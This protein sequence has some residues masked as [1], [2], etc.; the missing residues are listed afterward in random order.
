MVSVCSHGCIVGR[1]RKFRVHFVGIYFSVFRLCRAVYDG[2]F[3]FTP[4]PLNA[5]L[6]CCVLIVITLN[7]QHCGTCASDLPCTIHA[8]ARHAVLPPNLRFKFVSLTQGD[9]LT[10]FSQTYILYVD[11]LFYRLRSVVLDFLHRS[12]LH[13]HLQFAHFLGE[14]INRE[15]NFYPAVHQQI[16]SRLHQGQIPLFSFR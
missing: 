16:T 7:G 15:N 9:F 12:G 6:S 14:I 2:V 13:I 10:I 11:N 5:F 8:K 1:S 4:C 3:S